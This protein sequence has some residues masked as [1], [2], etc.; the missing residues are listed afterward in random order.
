MTSKYYESST[1][2]F[3][4]ENSNE[5]FIRPKRGQTLNIEGSNLAVSGPNGSVQYNKEGILA[6]EA[7]FLYD[8]ITNE[9][10]VPQISTDRLIGTNT[11]DS[12]GF[13]EI[14]RPSFYT[15]QTIITQHTSQARFMGT[16]VSISDNNYI[17]LACPFYVF[18][19]SEGC[20]S[21]WNNT[22]SS[23]SEYS[24]PLLRSNFT[25]DA[26]IDYCAINEDGTVIA[27]TD[28][29]SNYYVSIK[30][31]SG[32]VWNN[33]AL[34]SGCVGVKLSGNYLLTY[35]DNNIFK[36]HFYNGSSWSLQST[37]L[38]GVGGYS[39][40][41]L[42][43]PND[44]TAIFY[45][46]NAMRIYTRSSSTWTL[47][48]NI[49]IASV[50]SLDSSGT[51]TGVVAGGNLII[52]ENFAQVASLAILNSVY[53][54]TNGIYIFVTTNTNRVYIA[55]KVDNVWGL[56]YNYTDYTGAK[57]L[58]CNSTYLCVGAP[59][60]GTYGQSIIYTI[61][62]YV[63]ESL[64]IT[65]IEM[66]DKNVFDFY[67]RYGYIIAN[68]D[69]NT[70]KRF[71]GGAGSVSAPAYTFINDP[72]TGMF[73]DGTD[74]LGFSTNGS[75][76]LSINNSTLIARVPIRTQIGSASE[77]SYSFENDT[78]TG[79]YQ[80]GADTLYFSCG[81]TAR[82]Q[83]FTGRF[84]STVQVAS[85]AGTAVAPSFMFFGDDNT[86]MFNDGAD[87]LGFSTGGTNRFSINNSTVVPRVPIRGTNGSVSAP[88]YSFES[89][90]DTGVY[91]QSA[92]VM[93]ISCGGSDV[94]TFH[95]DGITMKAG[96]QIRAT[97][98]LDYFP[99]IG[100]RDDPDTG[101]FSY[102]TNSIGFSN[103]GVS[104]FRL[105]TSSNTAPVAIFNVLNSNADNPI[106][107]FEYDGALKG[108]ITT[109]G[110]LVFYNSASSRSLKKD[111]EY[112]C[113]GLSLI[114]R[115]KPCKYLWKDDKREK[116]EKSIGFIADEMK[117][118]LP[119]IV[120]DATKRI[121][122]SGNEKETPEMIDYSKIM[123]VV[124]CAA[125]Q[126]DFAQVYQQTQITELKNENVSLKERVKELEDKNTILKEIL[127]E[128]ENR[129]MVL[130][131][132]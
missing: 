22:G 29:D 47:N 114:R 132:V 28:L 94:S 57:K 113:G 75:N 21:V 49:T 98:G 119:E 76:K 110:L 129:L 13:N 48:Q 69:I 61:E 38:N 84:L 10:R 126:L 74:S 109:N 95:A 104:K 101:F 125:K 40:F 7:E 59:T 43:F 20:V 39:D 77:P 120:M 31:R 65:K 26:S 53:C 8:E 130:E 41:P 68:A 115:M 23:F 5:V 89:D 54:T 17:A 66:S 102:G 107:W 105:Q 63:N 88:S 71:L 1:H 32:S 70:T 2:V 15:P 45:Y 34:F 35:S 99:S 116:P 128:I 46:S 14:I 3:Y 111:I 96:M 106:I 37:L 122:D 78:N 12:L 64:V 67:S 4:S 56:S 79:M 72:N 81:G 50:T 73:N 44:S 33:D 87:S 58:S 82:L 127:T 6:G 131:K 19:N 121:D 92:N 18:D 80:V 97:T 30:R 112:G 16:D 117:E 36:I 118:V 24:S 123:P 27:F 103:G 25:T 108:S 55:R 90:T 60:I 42:S 83:L 62:P 52:Y 91:S 93:A 11:K 51:L 9:M 86:G 100:F 124:V 85:I